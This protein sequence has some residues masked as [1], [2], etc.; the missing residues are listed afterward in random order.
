M[1]RVATAASSVREVTST[2]VIATERAYADAYGLVLAAGRFVAAQDVAGRERVCVLGAGLAA[3]LFPRGDALGAAVRLGRHWY[4]VIGVLAAA[5][6]TD[7]T[8][9]ALPDLDRLA[10]VPLEP[11]ARRA[12]F[13]E[14]LL[15]FRDEADMTRAAAAVQRILEYGGEGA[16]FEYVVPVELI[17]QK[18][19]LQRVV[20]WLLLGVTGVLLTVGGISIAN[21]MLMSVL[22]RRGEIGLRRAIGA[23]R[24]SILEQFLAEGM[25]VCGVGGLAGVAAGIGATW[26]VAVGADWPV[27]S[28]GAAAL[29]GFCASLLVGLA[30]T[31]YPAWAAAGVEPMRVLA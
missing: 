10:I 17:R 8:A 1:Q 13:D 12:A 19:R 6:G 24:R 20:G 4:D 29:T 16:S 14:L 2:K 9:G 26:A 21:V 18:Y 5:D 30:A 11:P 3:E 25:L 7:G 31:S 22:R 28:V 23:S 15:E 27:A